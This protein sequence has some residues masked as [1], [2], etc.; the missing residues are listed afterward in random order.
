MIAEHPLPKVTPTP[1]PSAP[2]APRYGQKPLSRTPE[3]VYKERRMILVLMATSF[4]GTLA[5]LYIT[6][7]ASVTSEGYQRSQLRDAISAEDKEHL[8][9]Q[10]K[11]NHLASGAAIDQAA[12]KLG[13]VRNLNDIH[14]LSNDPKGH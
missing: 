7:H 4:F 13:L 10:R 5:L 12:Q 11:L 3:Q 1:P 2:S 8:D 14:Y 9:L 6:A